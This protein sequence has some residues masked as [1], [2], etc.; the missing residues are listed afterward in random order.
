M[1]SLH[2]LLITQFLTALAD[3][4]ILMATVFIITEQALGNVYVAIVQACFFIAYALLAPYAGI[5]SEKIPKSNTLWMGNALKLLGASLLF[6]GVNPAVS[7][8]IVGI[9]ACIY[10]PGKYAILREIT[11]D[12]QELYKANG[13]VEGSTIIAILLGTVLGGFLSAKSLMLAM[14]VIMACYVLSFIFALILPKG[15]VSDVKFSR[16]WRDF[17]RDV[18]TLVKIKEART[19]M[20]GTSSFWMTSSVLRLAMIAWIPIALGIGTDTASLYMG[21]SAIGI[22]VGA[23][24][25]PKIIKLEKVQKVVYLGVGMSLAISVVG[26][27][28]YAVP[29]AL[30]LFIAG[31]CGGAYMIP[32]NTILQE[33]GTVV[34]NGKTIAIQNFFENILMFSGTLLYSGALKAGVEIPNIMIGFGVFFLIVSLFVG[35]QFK[36]IKSIKS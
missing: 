27:L 2:K 25:S 34:G 17:G 31:F 6:M 1:K 35:T 28:P 20:I 21:V 4:A 12:E 8:A 14:I 30:I 15:E 36:S 7:Y 9:G 13:L 23:F 32:L 11:K 3:N 16:A 26:W 5:L 22:M 10:G 24:L 33:K 19:T 29:I 18:A